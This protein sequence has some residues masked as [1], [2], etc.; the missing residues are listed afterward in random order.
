MVMV[1]TTLTI[2]TGTYTSTGVRSTSR[3]P[4][5]PLGL[6]QSPRMITVVMTLG[7]V[8]VIVVQ[9]TTKRGHEAWQPLRGRFQ[10]VR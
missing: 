3:E 6:P 5:G 10:W 4:H 8:V 7:I 2:H 9:D 1:N